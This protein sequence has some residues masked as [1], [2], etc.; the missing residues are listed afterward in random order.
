LLHHNA[1][2]HTAEILCQLNFI[3]KHSPHSPDLVTP[4]DCHLF[5]PFRDTLR[6]YNFISDH[7]VKEAVHVWLV[8]QPETFFPVGI[9]EVWG[10][11]D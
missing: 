1:H 8:I 9:T 10:L 3:L 4:S 11:L 7:E 2:P 6:G 5:G